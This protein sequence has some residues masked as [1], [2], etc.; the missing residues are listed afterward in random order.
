MLAH[1]QDMLLRNSPLPSTEQARGH[2]FTAF[3]KRTASIFG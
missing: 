3:G 2:S 1:R